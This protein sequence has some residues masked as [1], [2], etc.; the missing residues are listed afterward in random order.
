MTS[1]VQELIQTIQQLS[2]PERE[3][4]AESVLKLLHADSAIQSLDGLKARYP[5]EWLAVIVPEGEDRY[6]PRQVRLAAHSPDRATVWQQIA[7]LR[8]QDI[9]VFYNGPVAAKGFGIAFHDTEDTPEP[10]TMGS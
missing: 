5:D 3:A 2:Q 1:R 9:F 8:E 10:A 6:E 7:P 4:I